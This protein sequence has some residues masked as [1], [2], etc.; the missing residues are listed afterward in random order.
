MSKQFK[1]ASEPSILADRRA[2]NG[3]VLRAPPMM[4]TR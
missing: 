4:T 3:R 2:L 1:I